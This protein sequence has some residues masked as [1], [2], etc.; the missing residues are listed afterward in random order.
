MTTTRKVSRYPERTKY[1]TLK[2]VVMFAQMN[3]M[4]ARTAAKHFGVPVN[5]VYHACYRMGVR[6]KA[7]R[8]MKANKEVA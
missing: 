1:G 2:Q 4:P 3:S 5:S 7:V 6:L 8:V